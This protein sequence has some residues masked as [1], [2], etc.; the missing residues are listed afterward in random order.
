MAY[1]NA[2]YLGIIFT[3]CSCVYIFDMHNDIDSCEMSKTKYQIVPKLPAHLVPLEMEV[4]IKLHGDETTGVAVCWCKVCQCVGVT[5]EVM[6]P[7]VCNLVILCDV[8]PRRKGG[9]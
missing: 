4:E 9:V 1:I 7:V 5:R 3:V 2:L 8:V 6:S